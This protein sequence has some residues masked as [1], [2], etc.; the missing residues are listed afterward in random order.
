[1]RTSQR[2]DVRLISATNRDLRSMVADGRFR[3]DLYYRLSVF[4][5]HLP[6]LRER[7][8]DLPALAQ[9]FLKRFAA[10]EVSTAERFSHTAL[11]AISNAPWPGN[12]RQLEN[13]IH[14]AV[15]MSDGARIEPSDLHGLEINGVRP[16]CHCAIAD[17]DE[18]ATVDPFVCD[19][20]HIR[21]L[22]EIEA[23]AISR[24]LSLYRG[25]MSETARRLGIGRSTLYRKIDELRI[26]KDAS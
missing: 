19:N 23:D 16:E 22:N 5:L 7:A 1:G 26:D 15:V 6:P 25:R 20:G 21:R 10:A 13:T 3:E 18:I 2:V 11:A 4:P 12:V 24:A 8:E 17:D 9:M 14:R